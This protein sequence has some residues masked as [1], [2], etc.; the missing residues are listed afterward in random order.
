MDG[1]GLELLMDQGL[2][3]SPVNLEKRPNYVLMDDG[4]KVE[5]ECPHWKTT[6]ICSHALAVAEKEDE[7]AIYL[8]WYGKLKFAKKRNL[9]S[10]ANLIVKKSTLGNKGKRPKRQRSGKP[11]SAYYLGKHQHAS[12]NL[13][14]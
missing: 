9:T 7:F 13:N 2:F 8:T 5:C 12:I 10:A 3:P 4:R 6:K 11:P 14:G 1:E